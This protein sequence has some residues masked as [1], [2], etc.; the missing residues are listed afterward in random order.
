MQHPRQ[1]LVLGVAQRAV[2]D[3]A[4]AVGDRVT[5]RLQLLEGAPHLDGD[6]ALAVG[7]R[8][9]YVGDRLDGLRVA[10]SDLGRDLA[11][12]RPTGRQRARV[13]TYWSVPATAPTTTRSS[14]SWATAA[15]DTHG[16]SSCER[17]RN[18]R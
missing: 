16:R 10:A 11:V 1:L 18:L 15:T 14:P 7:G 6:D 2:E 8:A 17:E 12:E 5:P 9:A 13:G 3:R 4:Q